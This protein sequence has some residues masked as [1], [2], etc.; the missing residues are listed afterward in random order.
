MISAFARTAR[1]LSDVSYLSTAKKAADFCLSKPRSPD[2]N[3]LKRWRQGK[4]GL[5]AILK[6]MHFLSKA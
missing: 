5:P 4:A 2:E 3:F 6:I 1:G